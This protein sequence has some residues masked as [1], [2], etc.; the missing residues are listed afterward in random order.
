MASFRAG[1]SG[2]I[3][4]SKPAV[5]RPESRRRADWC[6]LDSV[7]PA[8]AVPCRRFQSFYYWFGSEYAPNPSFAWYFRTDHGS[9]FGSVIA[10]SFYALAVRPSDVAAVQGVPEPQTLALLGLGLLGL[11]VARRRR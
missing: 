8:P 2:K 4:Q 3:E 10:D 6:G 11:A 9:Q 7:R 5:R 1:C